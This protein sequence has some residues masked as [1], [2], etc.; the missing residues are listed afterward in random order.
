MTKPDHLAAWGRAREQVAWPDVVPYGIGPVRALRDGFAIHAYGTAARGRDRLHRLLTAQNDVRQAAA[1]SAAL[2]TDL[3]ACWNRI[4]LGMP[5]AE[6]RRGPAYAKSGRERYGLHADTAQWFAIC[7]TEADD[8]SVPV[9]ARA[10]RAYLDVSFFHPF[11]DGNARLAA[12][13]LQFVL[14]REH[15]EL[16]DA[17]P[18]LTVLRRADDAEGAAGL[19]QLVHGLANAAHRRWLRQYPDSVVQPARTSCQN[20]FCSA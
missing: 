18:I 9:T 14:L 19:A 17:T 6:F 5:A 20:R 11:D 15:V 13:A 1:A 10:A 12:L 3:L 16:D 7:L 8:T 2:T 4:M